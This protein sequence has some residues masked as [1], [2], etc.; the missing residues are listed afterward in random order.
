LA[1]VLVAGLVQATACGE[2]SSDER[3]GDV[4]ESGRGNGG[5]TDGGTGARGGAS[6][7]SAQGGGA[8]GGVGGAGARGG[9]AGDAGEGPGGAGVGGDIQGGFGGVSG[10]AGS[11]GTGG[12]PGDGGTGGSHD[13]PDP[14]VQ[15]RVVDFWGA[16]LAGV[17]VTIG[18]VTVDTDANGA[19][20]VGEAP[21]QYD[22][23]MVVSWT[24]TQ[25]GVY[26][27]RYEGLTRRDPTLHVYRGRTGR[28]ANILI[29]P[30]N[31]TIDTS[32]NLSVVIAGANGSTRFRGVGANGVQSS[33]D[34]V[35]PVTMQ[36]TAHAL[37]WELDSNG[38][39]TAYRSYDSV[40]A[41]LVDSSSAMVT[42]SPTLADETITSGTVS[43]TVTSPV[44]TDRANQ[45][46]VRFADG[47]SIELVNDYPPPDDYSYLVPTLPTGA[48]VT[49]AASFGW[50]SL[51][52]AVAH[53]DGLAAGQQNVGMGIP[54]PAVQTAPAAGI[55]GV[56]GGTEFAW[57]SDAN[58]FVFHVEDAGIYQGLFVVTSR[59]RITLPSIA[60]YALRA[61]RAH[62]W[63][64]E[65]HGDGDS[66]D[67]FAS[68]QG[69]FDSIGSWGYPEGPKTGNGSFTQSL[70]RSF[71][72]AN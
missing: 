60:G 43:G 32:R 49:V 14:T 5:A 62:T 70:R 31:A 34:W 20:F 15:G 52:Y 13:D 9:T 63:Q 17:A 24:G 4:G 71:T 6:G 7:T 69:G 1:I 56:N 68:P 18:T 44:A 67:A 3:D 40:S 41:L 29:T 25:A 8:T 11:G 46:F 57:T 10:D 50:S 37:L 45:V 47:G 23:S 61:G 2:S 65:T 21:P 36:A 16:P 19:F 42:F 54:T 64:V 39:P 59:N 35:G 12:D 55:T 30:Q 22:V 38:L 48:T 58:V 51:D 66:V 28:Y 27:W 72:T 33:A 26:G 53:R